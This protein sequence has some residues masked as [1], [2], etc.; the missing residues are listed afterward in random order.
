MDT[1]R[2]RSTPWRLAAALAAA[3]AL[4]DGASGAPLGSALAPSMR[5]CLRLA[6]ALIRPA[7]PEPQPG[8][9]ITGGVRG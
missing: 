1:P 6:T 3:A 5:Q 2:R 4:A 7:A 9:A 8:A